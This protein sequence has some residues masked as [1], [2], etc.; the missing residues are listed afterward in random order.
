MKITKDDL[1]ITDNGPDMPQHMRDWGWRES[2]YDRF[3]VGFKFTTVRR[4]RD[5]GVEIR[6]CPLG[7]GRTIDESIDDLIRRTNMESGTEL[8]L[9]KEVE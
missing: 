3:N 6:G 7:R 2:D 1:E 8:M 4:L 9:G 5:E